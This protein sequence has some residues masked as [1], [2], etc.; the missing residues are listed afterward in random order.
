MSRNVDIADKSYK[1]CRKIDVNIYKAMSPKDTKG[2]IKA[3]YQGYSLDSSEV[4]TGDLTI[5]GTI[6]L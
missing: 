4:S 1:P 5:V 2:Q 3:T 6:V